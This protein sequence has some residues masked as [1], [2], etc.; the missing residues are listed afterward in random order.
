MSSNDRWYL[1]TQHLFSFKADTI[2]R[3]LHYS[4]IIFLL[5]L[6]DFISFTKQFFTFHF[7]RVKYEK[8]ILL[9]M[10]FEPTTS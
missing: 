10:R 6:G 5:I 8:Q 4:I 9:S 7:Y 2:F 3:A 1:D